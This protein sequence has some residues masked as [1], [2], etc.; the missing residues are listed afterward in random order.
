M[1][2]SKNPVPRYDLHKPSGQAYARY[3]DSTGTRRTVYFGKHGTPESQ[4]EYERFLLTIRTSPVTTPPTGAADLTVNE[5]LVAYTAHVTAYY[6]GDSARGHFDAL[7]AVRLVAGDLPLREF[8]PKVFKAVRQSFIDAMNSRTTINGRMQKISQFVKWCV[9]EELADPNLY[10]ALKAVPGLRKGRGEAKELPP[11]LPPSEADLER[12]LAK[13]PP[14]AAALARVQSLCGARAGE[15]VRL[16]A[17]AIDRTGPVWKAVVCEHKGTWRGKDRTLYF[18]PA[19]QGVLAP[20]MLAAAGEFVFLNERKRPYKVNGYRQALQRA[21]ASLNL[22]EYGT[23]AIR[24]F[25]ATRIRRMVDVETARVLLG[26]S[27]LGLT[28]E[29]YAQFDEAK[30]VDAMKR[31]G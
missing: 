2:R 20:L 13:M 26:H 12:I 25:A 16:R 17:D 15:L 14:A 31:V 22:P 3:T 5:A 21:C 29:V 27:D 7:R 6:P 19:A 1:P 10:A 24:H 4:Q 11:V 28:A 18:G 30:A 8:T 9:A 23:H